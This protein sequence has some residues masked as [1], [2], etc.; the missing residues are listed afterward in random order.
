M[1]DFLSLKQGEEVPSAG[2]GGQ[3]EGDREDCG[4]EIQTFSSPRRREEP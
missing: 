1:T 2:A 3:N 4:R